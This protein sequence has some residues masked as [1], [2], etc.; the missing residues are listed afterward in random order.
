MTDTTERR[1]LSSVL[2]AGGSQLGRTS[3]RLIADLILARLVL[4]EG[5]GI[6]FPSGYGG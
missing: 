4:P 1:F 5:H 2:S 6:V 3:L